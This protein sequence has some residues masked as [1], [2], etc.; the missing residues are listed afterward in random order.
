MIAHVVAH[1]EL[2]RSLVA[3]LVILVIWAVACFAVCWVLFCAALAGC[4]WH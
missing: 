3:L 2:A 4:N 1:P